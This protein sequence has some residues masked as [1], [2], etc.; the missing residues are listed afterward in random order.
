M[1]GIFIKIPK[2]TWGVEGGAG[3]GSANTLTADQEDMKDLFG[4]EKKNPD[5][6]TNRSVA[7]PVMQLV[8]VR[9]QNK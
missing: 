3:G 4:R 6:L 5:A 2:L 9:A 8:T 7:T 1:G